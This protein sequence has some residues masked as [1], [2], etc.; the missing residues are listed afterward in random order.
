MQIPVNPALTALLDSLPHSPTPFALQT[1]PVPGTNPPQTNTVVVCPS[2]K[3]SYCETCGVDYNA[4]NFMHQFLRAAPTD[5]IP[6][7]PNVAPPPQRAEQIKAAKEAGNVSGTVTATETHPLPSV[8]VYYLDMTYPM[9][10]L[11]TPTTGRIQEPAVRTGDP[12]LLSFSGYGTLPP[13]LGTRRDREGRDRDRAVQ[14]FRCFCICR[15]MVRR[16]FPS[17]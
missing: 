4:L 2:H 15:I 8:L 3:Q 16:R 13:A 1:V 12:T 5:A 10:Y 14:P 17:M 11:L 6:P 9:Y 7:P